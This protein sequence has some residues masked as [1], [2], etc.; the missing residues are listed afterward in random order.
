MKKLK[1]I[2]LSLGVLSLLLL[3][4]FSTFAQGAKGKTKAQLEQE[5]QSLQKE[6]ATAN[7]LL[8]QTAKTRELTLNEVAILNQKIRQRE[9]LIRAYNEQLA[10]LDQEINQGQSRIS[11]LNAD[12]GNLR[13]EY[14]KM[15]TFA[16]KNRSQYV[17]LGFLFASENFNQA[18]R[19]LRYIQ[20]F[21]EAR[22]VK[23]QQISSAEQ[24]ISGEVEAN[25]Q[26]REQQ[27][28]LL[29]DEQAQQQA[30]EQE[31]AELNTQVARLRTQ[32]AGIQ[33]DIR[34]KQQQAQKLQ[35]AIDDIIAEEIRKAN[36]EAEK[37]RRE[38]EAK[39]EKP[40]STTSSSG[41]MALTPS[42][43]TLSSNFAS[44]K[45]KLP[46]PVERGVISSSFGKH[47]SVVSDRVTVTN[48]GIDIATTEGAK[49]RAVFDGVVTNV[50]KLSGTNM[51][52][53]IRHGEYFT[54]YS[55]LE[56]V[57]VKSG[58]QVKTKQ[59]IGVVHTNRTENKTELHFELLKEIQRQDP[60][61]WLS[62]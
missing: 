23:M 55:N 14:A 31:R 15:I 13:K 11:S 61:N 26:A 48:N 8:R 7:Q 17:R 9:Q 40:T 52:V 45:G 51:V 25:R 43:Q 29:Q 33:Q 60:A 38:A 62:K 44:N 19:R 32:E 58:D 27:A 21:S 18:F 50:T 12:L 6:I 41:N 42:E 47:T 35:K 4:P 39:K 20:Q 57:S 49:A 22:K 30:L 24:Q 34:N 59:P 5:I 2:V 28:A 37:R 16:Y 1:Y 36:E 56:S 46:W 10:V 54:V 53:I 3:F